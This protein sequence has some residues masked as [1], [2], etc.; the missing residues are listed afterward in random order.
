MILCEHGKNKV[1]P[2]DGDDLNVRTSTI[3]V[4]YKPWIWTS[5]CHQTWQNWVRHNFQWH[6]IKFDCE[7]DISIRDLM[8]LSGGCAGLSAQTLQSAAARGA[9]AGERL[10]T[11]DSWSWTDVQETTRRE[12]QGA[13]EGF[14]QLQGRGRVGMLSAG[15]KRLGERF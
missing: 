1:R 11:G 5:Q 8:D 14:T 6:K 10:V 15:V 12:M 9:A 4:S 2:G 13:R 3:K 7:I